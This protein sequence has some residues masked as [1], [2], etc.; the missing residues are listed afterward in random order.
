MD[1]R[2]PTER[3]VELQFRKADQ[4]LRVGISEL[5]VGTAVLLKRPILASALTD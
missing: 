1:G 2:T 5:Q 4:L 3:G